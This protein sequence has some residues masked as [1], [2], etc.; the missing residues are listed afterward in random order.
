MLVIAHAFVA[1]A[2]V[3]YSFVSP[4]M[5][6]VRLSGRLKS[7]IEDHLIGRARLLL[8][9]GYTRRSRSS[10]TYQ[11]LDRVRASRS[12]PFAA[13]ALWKYAITVAIPAITYFSTDASALRSVRTFFGIE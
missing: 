5:V 8:S 2:I 13:Q 11:I 4:Q 7:E 1:A 12:A 10:T 6:L 3:I 9:E